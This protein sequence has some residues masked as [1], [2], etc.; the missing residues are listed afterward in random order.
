MIEWALASTIAGEGATK[1]GLIFPEEVA[2]DSDV[3]TCKRQTPFE[4][5]ALPKEVS[6]LGWSP[7]HIDW[8]AGERARC[9]EGSAVY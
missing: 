2:S 5:E 9:R 6:L 4:P 8:L 7:M 3:E 1:V